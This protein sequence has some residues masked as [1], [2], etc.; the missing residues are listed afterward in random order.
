MK[1][2]AMNRR[3]IFAALVVSPLAALVLKYAGKVVISARYGPDSV[4]F[5]ISNETPKTVHVK[6]LEIMID[7]RW[8]D[9]SNII[10]KGRPV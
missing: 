4:S 1:V 7:G 8:V 10:R 9:I 5:S 2:G 6:S 3:A